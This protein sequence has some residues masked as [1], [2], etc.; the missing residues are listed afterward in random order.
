MAKSKKRAKSLAEKRA[1]KAR[2]MGNVDKDGKR[3]SKSRYARKLRGEVQPEFAG[4]GQRAVCPWCFR[5]ACMCGMEAGRAQ[6]PVE[7]GERAAA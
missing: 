7:W 1:A 5:R 2:R 4:H 3:K 6:T